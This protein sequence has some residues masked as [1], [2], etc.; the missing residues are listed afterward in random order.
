MGPTGVGLSIDAGVVKGGGFLRFDFERDEYAGVL[1]LDIA[2]IVTVK[3]IG[4]ITTRLP[5]GSKGFSLLIIIT[6]EFS[7]IQLGLGFTLNGLGG[8]LGLNRTMMLERVAEGIRTGAI[9]SV[10]F[11]KD[12]VANAPRIISDLKSFFPPLNGVFLIGPMA[13]IGWGTPTIISLSLGVIIETPP[14]NIA[15]VGIARVLLPD[16]DAAL[17]VLQ[18]NFI[19]VFEADKQRMWFYAALFE[20]RVLFTPLDGDV[21][22]LVAWGPDSNLV[23]S[24]GGFH[25]AFNPPPLP[26]PNPKR[27]AL[28]LLSEP[29]ARVRVD[30]YFA[31]TSNTAQFGARAEVFFG[32]RRFS[33]NGHLSFDALYRFSPFYVLITISAS[34]GVKVFGVGLFSVRFRGQLEGST[35][36]HIEGE[37]SISL[38][39]FDIDVPF[40][41]TWGQEAETTLPPILV[42]PL[43]AAELDK[44]DNWNASIPASSQLLVSLRQLQ[45]VDGLVMHPLGTLRISQRAVPLDLVLDRIG[46]QTP[47]DVNHLSMAVESSLSKRDDASELF[48][49]AQF[50][51]L[52]DTQ[53]LAAPAFEPQHAGVELSVAGRQVRSDRAVR[54]TVRYETHIIDS[55]FERFARFVGFV[56]TL[57]DH[58]MDGNAAS[59]STLSNKARQQRVPV[60]R[61]VSLGAPSYVVASMQDNTPLDAASTGFTS[62]AKAN[63]FMREQIRKNPKLATI[64]HVIPAA[65]MRRAA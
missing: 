2:G 42:M 17:L 53:K 11:P 36:W 1:E 5:D 41:H 12:V 32:L 31:V 15:I 61:K 59:R 22:A 60:D 27:I 35:P 16:K 65:E 19:G 52:S 58:F 8:L 50:K 46:N 54:R 56:R 38:F 48:A 25:P 34:L 21:A 63:D 9:E 49:T 30:C 44:V 57:F 43:L 37:G 24:V 51:N 18:G 3:A 28:S 64:V 47:G 33:I 13:K 23:V 10:M 39:F 26:F 20:S 55:N 4:L 6:A 14:G 45:P 62:H 40:S 7:G 29:N